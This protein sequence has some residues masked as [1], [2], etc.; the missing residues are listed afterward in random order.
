MSQWV[1]ITDLYKNHAKQQQA[2]ATCTWEEKIEKV[3]RMRMTFTHGSWGEKTG[4]DKSSVSNPNK[5]RILR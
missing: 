1:P 2:L 5:S 3:K 4:N